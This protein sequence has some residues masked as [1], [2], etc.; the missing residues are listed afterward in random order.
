MTN[1][2]SILQF[3]Y[4]RLIM[5]NGNTEINMNKFNTRGVV[6]NPFLRVSATKSQYWY[7]IKA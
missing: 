4:F 1:R 6:I 5:A 3:E 2:I 7:S